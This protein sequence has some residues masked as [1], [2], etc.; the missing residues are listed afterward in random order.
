MLVFSIEILCIYKN[1]TIISE[2]TVIIIFHDQHVVLTS[3]I[4]LSNLSSK[5]FISSLSLINL[6]TSGSSSP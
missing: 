2:L 6:E 3:A 1:N 5:A 4:C